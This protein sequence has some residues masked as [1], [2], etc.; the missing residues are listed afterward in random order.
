MGSSEVRTRRPM[1]RR[2]LLM[3]GE[4][5]IASFG[6]ALAIILV[7]ATLA[8][9]LWLMHTQ[10]Q[11]LEQARQRQ[12]QT[13]GDLLAPAV[14]QMLAA[15]ELSAARQML[16]DAADQYD[17]VRCRIVAP[18]NAVIADAE[19]SRITADLSQVDWRR[20]SSQA[21]GPAVTVSD[22]AAAMEYPIQIPGKGQ[23]KLQIMAS[24]NTQ[25]A[26]SWES[27]AGVGVV[28]ASA[29]FSLLLAYR[30]FR[31]RLRAVGV[32]REALI[33]VN[34]GETALSALSVGGKLSE[35]AQAWNQLLTEHQQLKQRLAMDEARQAMTVGAASSSELAAGCDAI[36]QGMVLIGEDQRVLYANPAAGV[37]LM[38]SHEELTGTQAA[39][40]LPDE[41]LASTLAEAASGQLRRRVTIE[42]HR[43]GDE[44]AGVLR[45]SI[46]P[47]RKGDVSAAILIIE[48]VTQQRIAEQARHQFVAQATHELRTPLTNILLYVETAQDEGQD[49]PE[50]RAR[51]LD[52]IGQESHRLERLVGD[53]LSVAEIEAGSMQICHD[54]VKFDAI[55]RDIEADYKA[56]A[57]KKR[58]TLTFKIPPKLPVV[59]GDR[60]KLM[61]TV[62]NLIANALKY[63]P[64]GGQV[65]VVAEAEDG[66]L[67]VSIQDTG[68]GIA[69]DDLPKVFEKFYRARDKRIAGIT[70]SGLGLALSRQIAQL[71]GGD[72]HADSKLDEGSTFTLTL[73]AQADTQTATQ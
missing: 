60:D 21:G 66:Q 39:Q 14:E 37:Y 3:R 18:D 51:C 56:Q 46:H 59:Q 63:T 22:T 48:D 54:D 53:M 70:G 62:Q 7:F 68:L 33:D 40:L 11:S 42:Q 38:R 26:V 41:K 43:E 27:Q 72:V 2:P 16:M 35:E 61:L 57:A 9:S 1:T 10:T 4:S 69:P 23:V 15:G 13:V 71:H 52:V 55:L 47:V 19:P 50:L 65:T 31:S 28:G 34:R 29:L 36:P 25:A 73:P 30:H 8:F 58:I 64:D 67:S 45:Y 32:I 24:V 12:V 5:A 17:L 49:D 6:I 20:G 44:E